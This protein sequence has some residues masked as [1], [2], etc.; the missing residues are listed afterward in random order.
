MKKLLASSVFVVAAMALTS[1]ANATLIQL[2]LYNDGAHPVPET[3]IPSY[4]NTYEPLTVDFIG[5]QWDSPV[6]P[7]YGTYIDTYNSDNTLRGY[8][9][10]GNVFTYYGSTGV[11]AAEVQVINYFFGGSEDPGLGEDPQGNAL[12]PGQIFR[13]TFNFTPLLS[14]TDNP[15]PA[16]GYTLSIT[17]GEGAD[18]LFSAAP[19]PEPATFGLLGTALLGIGM[20]FR[21]RKHAR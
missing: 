1:T 11:F 17:T 8:L 2:D 19:V 14:G 21:R 15:V 7:D 3:P 10:L 5:A 4:L 20:A 18:D 9:W 13:Q 12:P 6:D 16:P